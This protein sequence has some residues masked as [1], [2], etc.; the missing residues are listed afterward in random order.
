MRRVTAA[1]LS[2]G[3]AF[4]VAQ[5]SDASE[6][7]ISVRQL[8]TDLGA[9]EFATR[10]QAMDQLIRRPAAEAITP[11]RNAVWGQD[12]DMALRA[13]Q[14]LCHYARDGSPMIRNDAREV[15]NDSLKLE[16][17]PSVRDALTKATSAIERL[18]AHIA[19]LCQ[20]CPRD[21]CGEIVCLYFDCSTPHYATTLAILASR[22]T[23]V[24]RAVLWRFPERGDSR[25]LSAFSN[26]T[27]LSLYDSAMTDD[28]LVS[29]SSCRRLRNLAISS[30]AGISGK[31][32]CRLANACELEYVAIF[33]TQPEDL[34]ALREAK[35]LKKLHLDASTMKN[36]DIAVLASIQSVRHLELSNAQSLTDEGLRQLARMTSLQQL[37]ITHAKISDAG[38][39]C[40]MALDL[41][42]LNISGVPLT[43]LSIQRIAE[44]RSLVSLSLCNS[45]LGDAEADCL[46]QLPLLESLYLNNTKV[47][48][49]GARLISTC[50]HLRELA[51]LNTKVSDVGIE[52][53]SELQQ[54]E[55]LNVAGTAMTDSGLQHL[56][57]LQHLESLDISNC[58][59][60][61][62]GVAK[63]RNA[64]PHVKV[65]WRT[66]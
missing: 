10:S 2:F 17:S 66:R 62:E 3:L 53:L 11:L 23:E 16:L 43:R 31:G 29:L 38:I 45:G 7:R 49:E 60:T 33:K 13:I 44:E 24:R 21:E 28:D 14:V 18:E 42:S 54:L 47:T 55:R 32:L 34:A 27:E 40:L 63:F 56:L 4:S 51:L 52:R 59:V 26:L 61:V 46:N 8:V 58:N 30:C 25:V 5:F 9:R 6:T 41:Q 1:V 65:S 19:K 20:R 35:T 36:A 12:K 57:K 48:D 37:L 50:R 64:M 15:L 22:C 39:Q